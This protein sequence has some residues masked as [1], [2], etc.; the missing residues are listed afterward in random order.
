MESIKGKERLESLNNALERFKEVLDII[1]N[2][3]DAST[4]EIYRDS[5]IKRFEFSIDLFWK[6]L[7]DILYTKY[8]IVAASPKL[9]AKLSLENKL[10]SENEYN[11]FNFMVDDRN[12]TSHTYDEVCA[13]DIFTRLF[14]HYELMQNIALKMMIT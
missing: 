5:A 4:Y 14:K 6:S 2:N 7:K 10:I 13:E 3:K 1:K 12:K 11:Q 8:G 9:V